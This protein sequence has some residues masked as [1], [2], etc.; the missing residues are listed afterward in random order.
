MKQ[1]IQ[2]ALTLLIIIFMPYMWYIDV[3][4]TKVNFSLADVLLI[5]AGIM[6]LFNLKELFTRKRWFIMLY[7]AGLLFSLTLSHFASKLNPGFLHAPNS[8]LLMEIVKTIVTALYLLCAF[9]FVDEKNF[10][11]TAITISLGSIPV[12]VIGF[13]AYLSHIT[14]YTFPLQVYALKMLRFRGTFEDPNLCALYFIVIFY[15]SLYCFRFMQKRFL[16][17]TM[18]TPALFSIIAIVLTQSRGGWLAFGGSILIFVLLSIRNIHKESLL[19]P[20]AAIIVVLLVLNLDYLL[21]NG[22]TTN[23]IITRVQMTV[24]QD[25]EDIDRVQL[26][27][28]AFQM[29]NDNFIVGVGKG[30]FPLNT[31]L[32]LGENSSAYRYQNIPHNTLLGFY[33]Q[34]GIVGLLLFLLLPGYIMFR[35][36]LSC[37]GHRLYFIALLVGILIHSMTINLENI[38]FVWFLAG[39]FLAVEIKVFQNEL[40]PTK[41]MGKGAYIP[42]LSG[43]LCVMLVLYS[44]LSLKLALNPYLSGGQVYEKTLSSLEPGWYSLRFDLQTDEHLHTVEVLDGENLIWKMDFRSAYGFVDE[45]LFISENFKIRFISN[46]EGWL[47]AN[48]AYLQNETAKFPLYQYPLLPLPLYTWANNRELLA[49]LDIPSF[50]IPPDASGTP[51][52][53]LKLLDARIVKV[54]N[55][56]HAFEFT[57]LCKQTTEK[58]YHMDLLMD[59]G[60]L[61]SLLSAENQRNS[62]KHRFSINPLTSEWEKDNVYTVKTYRL[63]SCLDFQLYGRYYD[64]ENKVYDQEA[65]FPISWQEGSR[66]QEILSS[67]NNLWIN[68][69]YNKYDGDMIYMTYNGWVESGRMNLQAGAHTLKFTA[70]GTW[71]DGYPEIRILDNFLNEITRITL[72]DTMRDYTVEY[73]TEVPL[74]GMSFILELTNYK[75][76]KDVGNRKA[77]LKETF[78]VN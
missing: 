24:N 37:G 51:F 47:K 5:P 71:L 34:Q 60:S 48:N 2:T 78:E 18:V 72:D 70:Q 32:Y 73:Y 64:F 11:L 36:I 19:L 29:G 58:N 68:F 43:L 31:N 39:I 33:A 76:E 1:K 42:V 27:K 8:V 7:F 67:D 44:S 12:M 63:L 53:G 10:K 26:M 35:L 15:T 65:Y 14:G 9:V 56:T 17:W 74:E 69:L 46:E 57:Y 22:K 28:A 77:I 6:M 62:L 13:A 16:R 30:S 20:L 50:R 45:K 75:S 38:R 54:S 41:T 21:Q 3:A 61:T 59:F 49:Y 40:R 55:L 23:E 25:V 4:G 52:E 66:N